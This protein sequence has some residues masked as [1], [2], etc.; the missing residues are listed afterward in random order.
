MTPGGLEAQFAT[1]VLASHV[2]MQGLIP[3]MPKGGRVVLVASRRAGGLDVDDLQG[4]KQAYSAPGFHA[5][6]KQ[7]ARMQ[8]AEAATL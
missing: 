8:A 3:N 1:N 7:A 5:A 2:L 6:T 4:T